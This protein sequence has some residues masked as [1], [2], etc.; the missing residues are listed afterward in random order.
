[1]V[2]LS[3]W[4]ICSGPLAFRLTIEKSGVILIDLSLYITFSFSL[5]DFIILSLFWMFSILIVYR[6][7]FIFCFSLFTILV[8]SCISI[9]I[10]FLMLENFSSTFCWNYFLCIWLNFSPFPIPIILRFDLFVVSQIFYVF[11]AKCILD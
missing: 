3:M 7:Y 5:V 6:E 11:Y 2:F 8:V 10:S 4:R 1:M 9:G